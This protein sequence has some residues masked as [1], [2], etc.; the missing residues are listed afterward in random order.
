[1]RRTLNCLLFCC[2]TSFVAVAQ[3]VVYELTSLPLNS[4]QPFVNK[5][6]NWKITGPLTGSHTDTKPKA[7]AGTGVLFNDFSNKNLY[8][9]D[10]N[11]FTTLEHGDIVLSLDVLVPRGS[12]S[13]IYLQGRYEVQLFDSWGKGLLHSSDC[14]AIY[15][16]W[17]ESRPEGKKGYEGH[18]PLA[19]ACFAPNLWQ[20]LEIE[21]KAPRF[22]A[23]GKKIQPARFVKVVLNGVTVQKNV[24]VSGTTRSAAFTDEKPQGP[25]MLQ[26]DHG[27]VAFR[28]I[29]YAL[30][31]DFAIDRGPVA[32]RYYEGKFNNDLSRITAKD[33]TRSGNAEA[34]DVKLADDPNNFALVFDGKINVKEPGEYRFLI[35]HAGPVKLAI[36]GR[37]M[38]NSTDFFREEPA[39][40]N[41]AAGEHTY[42]L[43]YVRNF[44]WAPAGIGLWLSKK[45][46]RPIALHES[47]SLPEPPAE[48]LIAV[49][50][51]REPEL[52]RSF[53]MH[54][55]KKKTHVISIGYP[56]GMNVA[57]DLNQAALLQ[58]WKGAFL[59]ATDMWYERGEPQTAAPLGAA[60]V[61]PGRSAL[62]L[63]DA[64]SAPLP[65]TLNDRTEIVYK[66]YTLDAGRN[67]QFAYTLKGLA[68]TDQFTQD[69]T[70]QSLVR[71]LRWAAVPTG[72]TLMLRLAVAPTITPLGNNAYTIGDQQHYLQLLSTGNAKPEI[73]ESG[74]KKELLLKLE[75][76]T[77]QTQYSIIW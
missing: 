63:L 48:P 60:I 58:T 46:S 30:L 50:P 43:S 15:E 28:N 17:D 62:A 59:N 41:L 49:Q 45:N 67:P 47:T 77:L 3:S 13:G 65:D 71:T 34:I 68:F 51:G 73:R 31:N 9:E 29:R 19:N 4:L 70:G 11:L 69:M 26:G 72:K 53:M 66:G 22:D 1:M 27:A 8:K 24:L 16:R 14:G 18:P 75:P 57:Y 74:G 7:S 12:N 42:T 55:G 36:D 10:A 52:I 40:V 21:F 54:E 2:F 23:S 39:A 35:K 20:H 6:A 76:G 32:Y 5:A 44:N 38:V 25:L 56:G 64:P 37:E 33:V 61:L